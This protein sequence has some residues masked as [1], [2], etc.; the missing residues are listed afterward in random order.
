M[1]Y[2]P[3][4]QEIVNAL[5]RF[6]PI[7]LA[8]AN[9]I[10][11]DPDWN[12][13]V[14]AILGTIGNQNRYISYFNDGRGRPYAEIQKV[15]QEVFGAG[16]Q[17]ANTMNEWLYDLLWWDQGQGHVIDIPLVAEIEWGNANQ[18]R[19]DFQKLLLA[20]S[21]YRVV[22]FQSFNETLDWC[23]TLI[24]ELITEHIRKFK[25]TISGDRYLF[26]AYVNNQYG[27]HFESY[28]VPDLE[29]EKRACEDRIIEQNKYHA[30]L[31]E[32]REH[33]YSLSVRELY[34]LWSNRE[35]LEPDEV[36]LLRR[37][38]RKMRGID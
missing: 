32:R 34:E 9:K 19:D 38:I 12:K 10:H 5:T 4:E 2:D 3:I 29:S 23:K 28:V 20:R 22:V 8:E 18:I 37:V 30:Y 7:A 21:K 31:A 1:L 24:Q 26:C 35:E 16:V 27:F 36:E 25:P 17:I 6:H 15:V 33:Y 13:A 14:K 11:T